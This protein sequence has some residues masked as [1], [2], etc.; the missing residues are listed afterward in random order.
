MKSTGQTK[1][2]NPASLRNRNTGALEY[3]HHF[4]INDEANS[5]LLSQEDHT[6]LRLDLQAAF[7]QFPKTQQNFLNKV[8]FHGY[9]VEEAAGK[10]TKTARTWRR[11]FNDKASPKLIAFLKDYPVREVRRDFVR[12]AI[13]KEKKPEITVK[14]KFCP[15]TFTGQGETPSQT[16]AKHVHSVHAEQ[17]K[18]V[19]AHVRSNDAELRRLT[20][21]NEEAI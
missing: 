9:T 2:Y 17:F 15:N 7:K 13:A 6:D 5:N 18:Q 11:W 21:L 8:F 3:I 4:D 1:T 10:R 19:M 20:Y 16:C 12:P 14:C